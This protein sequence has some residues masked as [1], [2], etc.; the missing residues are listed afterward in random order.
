MISYVLNMA[1]E[2]IV[3][4]VRAEIDAAHRQ[5]EFYWSA[6][7]DYLVQEDFDR[8]AYGIQDGSEYSLVTV[9]AQLDIEPRVERNYWILSILVHKNLGPQVI[10]DESALMAVDLTLDEFEQGFLALAGRTVGVRLD[11]QTLQAKEHFDRWWADLSERHPREAPVPYPSRAESVPQL[12][13]P[14]PTVQIAGRPLVAGQWSYL[15]REAVGVFADPDAL[16][17][18]ADELEIAGF[19]RASISVLGAEDQVKERIGRLYRSIAEIEDDGRAPRTVFVS[20]DARVEGETAAVGVPFYIGGV[21][22]GA[23]VV[24]SGG[25][26]S[27]AI[28]ATIMVG[29]AAAGFGAL[30]AHAVA[31]H[32]AKAIEQQLARGGL[33]LWVRVPDEDAE[34]R[35]LG[36]LEKADAR[37]VHVHQMR[38][39]WG[40][41]DR[42]R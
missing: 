26:L 28:A 19:D 13:P 10:E 35:A 24:A 25:A 12:E 30:L 42:L 4:V 29:T 23:A 3:R 6:S 20:K 34:K 36:I 11:A 1:P 22:G 16:E 27:V 8:R 18:A 21:A 2:E 17:T 14:E 37:H 39:R 7:E 40:P 41:K 31:Q 38:R 5:P 9:E 32:Q 15:V 33:V